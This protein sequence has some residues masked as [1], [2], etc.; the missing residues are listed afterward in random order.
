M[1]R[2]FFRPFCLFF[3]K[4]TAVEAT[5]ISLQSLNLQLFLVQ[6]KTTNLRKGRIRAALNGSQIVGTSPMRLPFLTIVAFYGLTMEDCFKIWILISTINFGKMA[7]PPSCQFVGRLWAGLP[8]CLVVLPSVKKRTVPPESPWI[9]ARP[10]ASWL[11][12][13]VTWTRLIC[14][15]S[16]LPLRTGGWGRRQLSTTRLVFEFFRQNNEIFLGYFLNFGKSVVVW[17]NF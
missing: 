17:R 10:P 9:L 1:V 4:P 15:E 7:T 12:E 14:Q 11:V 6:L 3:F 8:A 13:M 5:L 2:Q 16:V